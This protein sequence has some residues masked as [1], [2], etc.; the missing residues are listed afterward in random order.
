MSFFPGEKEQSALSTDA[1][2]YF[3]TIQDINR[4]SYVTY[5]SDFALWYGS[6]KTHPSFSDTEIYIS[7]KRRDPVIFTDEEIR[8]C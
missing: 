4:K 6:W 2:T 7:V 1:S 5:L 8:R 3:D